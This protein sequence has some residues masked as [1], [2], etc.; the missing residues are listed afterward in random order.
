MLTWTIAVTEEEREE[1]ALFICRHSAELGLLYNWCT[2][3]NSLVYCIEDNGL[4]IGRGPGGGISG[5]LAHTVGTLEDG[6]KDRSRI[7][8]HLLFVE[9]G[10][11]RGAALLPAVRL[12]TRKLLELPGEVSEIVFF[13]PSTEEN[14][15][16]FGQSAELAKTTEP[17]C[18][19]L[20]FYTVAFDR[21]LRLDSA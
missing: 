15:L 4:L 13:A 14:R 16:K 20:D 12:L 19:K 17:P 5:V 18:G 6:Y 10:R 3:M 2:V 7:E 8:V 1:A 9:G 11:R 21:M